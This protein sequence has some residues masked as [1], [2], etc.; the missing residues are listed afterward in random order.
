MSSLIRF[1]CPNCSSPLGAPEEKAGT[2]RPCPYCHER[3]LVP[4]PNRASQPGNRSRATIALLAG[5]GAVVVFGLFVGLG[6]LLVR[7]SKRPASQHAN[8]TAAQ[9]GPNAEV[10]ADPPGEGA[11]FRGGSDDDPPDVL[12]ELNP[13]ARGGR[14]EEAPDVPP[15]SGK[16]YT[17]LI[18]VRNYK[19]LPH[20]LYTEN[21]VTELAGLLRTAGYEVVLLTGSG[22]AGRPDLEPTGQNIR[23]HLERLVKRCGRSDA[24]LLAFAGH[25]L[26]VGD[27]KDS[28]FCPPEADPERPETLVSLTQIYQ[29]L[30]TSKAGAKLMLVDACRNQGRGVGRGIDGDNAPRPPR[31]AAVLFSCSPGQQAFETA[32]LGKGHG[33]FF[34]FVL[35]GLK[36]KAKNDE[37][38]VTWDS[39]GD[40]VKRQVSRQVPTIIGGGARQ[41]PHGLADLIGESP[42]L[43]RNRVEPRAERPAP[44]PKNIAAE[45][46]KRKE[47]RAKATQIMQKA[48][49]DLPKILV[50]EAGEVAAKDYDDDKQELKLTI[51]V[52]ADMKQY[53]AFTKRVGPLMDKVSLEKTSL[54]VVASRSAPTAPLVTQ[55]RLGFMDQKLEEDDKKTWFLWMLTGVDTSWTRLRWNG[56]RVDGDMKKSLSGITGDWLVQIALLD[57]AGKTITEDELSLDE[58]VLPHTWIAHKCAGRPAGRR[59]VNHVLL[60]PMRMSGHVGPP[61]GGGVH[62]T[63]DRSMTR[64]VQL[65]EAD[66]K[67]LKDIRCKVVFRP[68]KK[69]K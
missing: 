42:V 49:A 7:G 54:V 64:Q 32:K 3:I 38:A 52:R 19:H 27:E 37:G 58:A 1:A 14:N 8:S 11:A 56:Y 40:Y 51:T 69:G 25:G 26:Q 6:V 33:V 39:L 20:L 53:A 31:G 4:A 60:A 36:G 61:A 48:F 15:G 45:V 12:P 13:G 16:R 2:Q 30:K 18:G 41:T 9:Q 22:G 67:R 24:L 66:L 65:S 47:A 10:P 50:A 63:P 68:E 35:E 23:D 55:R 43:V 34:H 5:A 57:K 62:F 28:F 44:P 21:D 29:R 59:L 17:L 46:L